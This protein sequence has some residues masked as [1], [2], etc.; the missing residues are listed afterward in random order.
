MEN[1]KKLFQQDLL[2][3][4]PII[5]LDAV[6]QGKIQLIRN[7]FQVNKP[8]KVNAK[9]FIKKVFENTDYF[10]CLFNKNV[11]I[12]FNELF[13]VRKEVY[14]VIDRYENQKDKYIGYST[15]VSK[16]KVDENG[17]KKKRRTIDNIRHTVCF[18][19]D[20]DY[21]KWD[22][23]EGQALAMI[24]ELVDSKELE[25]P[26]IILFTGNGIQLIWLIDN[27][28][29][30]QGSKSHSAWKAV[31]E[32]MIN[33]L[34]DLNPDNVV[35]NP[36]AVTRLPNTINSRNGKQ[37]RA[38]LLRDERLPL[39]YFIENYLPVPEPDVRPTKRIGKVVHTPKL[40]SEFSLN[41]EREN[42]VFRIVRYKQSNDEN[43]V[44]IRQHLALVLR[45][46]ALVS[47]NGDYDYAENQVCDLWDIIDQREHTTLEEVLRRSQLAERYYQEY[48]G[49]AK[50]AGEGQY[51]CPGLFYKNTTLVKQWDLSIECQIQ[52][53]T[54]KVKNNEYERI[55]KNL[56]RRNKGVNDRASYL[57]TE[58]SKTSDK[59]LLLQ[60]AL[61]ANPEATRREL[62]E[63][64]GVTPQR[65]TQLR[66]LI[67]G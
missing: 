47:S 28:H 64:L 10:I 53:K 21:Y 67:G 19:Q 40:W 32:S 45:F 33:V 25:M 38:Y 34:R 12:A 4:E 16:K 14:R 51:K 58:K 31:Q 18:V 62:A 52:L 9:K 65:I 8:I 2:S 57:A 44:G 61:K 7:Y 56:E 41:R 26:S 43:I 1:A 63:M 11:D 60:E 54:I 48:K 6:D 17:E 50:W 23:S 42:D 5:E 29:M 46:H 30:K 22:I 39:G 59:V 24:S 20:L 37:V 55:R 27:V 35:K 15:F 13:G 49:E 66:K 36:A 3:Q